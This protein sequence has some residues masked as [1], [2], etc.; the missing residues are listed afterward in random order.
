[1]INKLPQHI[2]I[3]MDGNGRWAKKRH[4]PRVAGHRKGKEAVQRIVKACAEKG[5]QV[6]T[7]FAFSTENWCRPEAEVKA[8]LDLFLKALAQEAKKLH[9]QNIR[10]RMIGDTG[11]FDEQLLAQMS[12]AQALTA[13]NTGLTL[14]IAVD[15]GGRWDIVQAAKKIIEQTVEQGVSP[16]TVTEDM[17]ASYLS[18]ADLPDPD[19]FIRTSGEQRI[20]N[21]LI[22]QLAYTELFFT[23]LLWP[24]FDQTALDEALAFYAMRQRRLGATAE[25][26]EGTDHA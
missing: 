3:V 24:D 1:M 21:F 25:Q 7:L 4:L 16:A 15:Y 6:L 11:K 10:L 9:E 13:N 2:A 14:V 17:F 26:L 20:S 18:C 19:L 22:W 12:Q 23:D 5:I 8:L